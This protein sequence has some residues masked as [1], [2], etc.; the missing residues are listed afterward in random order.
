MS[1]FIHFLDADGSCN[2]MCQTS[3]SNWTKALNHAGL[4]HREAS[5]LENKKKH[6]DWWV[7]KD[8]TS[9]ERSVDLKGMKRA[10]GRH[11]NVGKDDWKWMWIEIFGKYQ[12][13]QTKEWKRINGWLLAETVDIIA[14]EL[15]KGFLLVERIDLLK[16]CRKIVDR[17]YVDYAW[18]AQKKLYTRSVDVITKIHVDDITKSKKIHGMEVRYQLLKKV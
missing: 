18:Q 2:Q 4:I 3:E 17:T 13:Y 12:N 8:I 15:P 9:V 16:L 6:I 7:Q 10:N 14:F 11:S 1:E 5:Y